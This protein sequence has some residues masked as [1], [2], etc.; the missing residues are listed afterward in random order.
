VA[1]R[2]LSPPDTRESPE[3]GATLT[4]CVVASYNIH[5]CRGLDRR[6]DPERI[7]RVI[8]EMDPDVIGLQEV[9]SRFGTTLDIHQLNYLAEE[10]GMQAVAGSTVLRADS[11]YGNALLTRH[12]VCEVRT[13][14][15]SVS[16]REP[17][18]IL[19]VDLEVGGHK[20][21]VLVTHLGLGS[22]ERR[23]QTRKLLEAVAAHPDEPVVVLSDFNEWLPWRKP[24]RW[25]HARLG[26]QPVLNTFPAP[27]PIMALD[28]IWVAPRGNLAS[29]AVHCSDLARVA[30]DHLPLRAVVDLRLPRDAADTPA[31]T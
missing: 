1:A 21:R 22:R 18:G 16:R 12:R 29:I 19:D 9:E 31:L 25:M 7:A 4:R 13:L 3:A 5:R 26:R 10:T 28:R 14:D 11:H 15:V 8:E 17:R 20:L 30:S 24:L 27:W 6:N 2:T 23:R